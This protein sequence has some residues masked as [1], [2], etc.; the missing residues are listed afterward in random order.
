MFTSLFVKKKISHKE[1]AHKF[2]HYTLQTIEDTYSDFLDAIFYD[3]EL[4]KHP[5]LDYKDPRKFSLII[6]AGNMKFFEQ[7]LSSYEEN[8]LCQAIIE[9]MSTAF[10][11]SFHEMQ[12]ELEK[13]SSFISRV[14]HPSKNILY[15]MSKAVFF[16][17]K[18]GKYQEDYFA[19]LNT[20]N[21]IFLKRIDNLVENY[22]WDWKSFFDKTKI[23]L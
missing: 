4:T 5:P 20:P 15:G 11:T 2:V 14:N 23:T 3:P 1:I 13:Y 18:L 17:F 21:P 8:N 12:A 22:I 19:Q 10:E 9:E 7:I 16:K 6:I